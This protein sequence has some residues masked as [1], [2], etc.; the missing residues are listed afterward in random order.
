[1]RGRSSAAA[2]C[3]IARRPVAPRWR[4]ASLQTGRLRRNHRRGF[5]ESSCTRSRPIRRW[6]CGEGSRRARHWS[7]RGPTRLRKVLRRAGRGRP[8]AKSPSLPDPAPD[9]AR[10]RTSDAAIS[11]LLIS[12]HAGWCG[13]VIVGLVGMTIGGGLGT[14]VLALRGVGLGATVFVCSAAELCDSGMRST[15]SARDGFCSTGGMM[16]RVSSTRSNSRLTP[17]ASARPD[18]R[19]RSG[20][21]SYREGSR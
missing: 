2:G 7:V 18:A 4:G 8:P 16:P 13:G 14:G 15:I 17:S 6:G 19:R 9:L 20:G 11:S 3:G 12:I 21:W 5:P 1:M 10:L